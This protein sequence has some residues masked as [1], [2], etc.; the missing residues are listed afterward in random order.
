MATRP[1]SLLSMQASFKILILW[2][3]LSVIG[4]GLLY[5]FRNQRATNDYKALYVSRLEHFASRHKDLLNQTSQLSA[6]SGGAHYLQLLYQGRHDLKGMDFWLRY[7]NPVQYKW[8]N[9]PLPVEWET[10]VF[11]KFEKPYKRV[12]AGLTL[13]ELYLEEPKFSA[14]SLHRLIALSYEALNSYMAD[15][16]TQVLNSPDHFYYCNRLFLLNLATLYT[17]GFECPNPDRVIPE[18]EHMLREVKTIYIAF[19]SSFPLEAL[20]QGYLKTYEAAMAFVEQ[21]PKAH[22]EFDHFGFI[23]DFV[24]PLFSMNQSLIKE[25]GMKSKSYMDYTLNAGAK[26]IFSKQLY[27]GQYA[28]GIF[29]RVTKAEELAELERL[30]KLLFYD[31]LLSGNDLRSCASCHSPAGY[32]CDTMRPTAL[33]FNQ[34][35]VLPRN[36]PSL[37]NASFNHLLM[38]DGKHLGLQE[39]G[40]AVVQNPDEMNGAEKEVMKK[41]LSC[42]DYKTGFSRL[43]KY[44]PQEKEIGF[45]HV[46]SAITY[47]YDKFSKYYSPFDAAMNREQEAEASV[48]RGFNV[49]MSKAQCGTC[50]FAP[51]FNGVKPPY[52]NSEFEVLGVPADSLYTTL[53]KDLGRYGVHQAPETFRAF[54]TGTLRNCAKTKPYMHNGVFWRLEQVID[55][56][57]GGGGAGH[58]LKVENQT[59]SGDSLHLTALEKSDLLSFLKSLTEDIPFEA[60]PLSLPLSK[61]SELNKRVVGGTY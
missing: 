9:G 2:L 39:Q 54:R 20:P 53:S 15:S 56:Y 28:K 57:D 32:F 52:V 12:G 8:M 58:G 61:R 25:Y 22:S 24:N 1:V 33:H 34:Q 21:A 31:P 45:S 7:L 41:I 42:K 50:H 17:S 43:I 3:V 23:R 26:S 44:T 51:H 11:E 48:K 4:L 38:A 13:A 18:L 14:D 19:N 46:V 6:A 40:K 60:P 5:S 16:I 37:L 35:D 36:S 47:Y 27:R 49:F 30:G 29:A 10:E 59:L 55:F